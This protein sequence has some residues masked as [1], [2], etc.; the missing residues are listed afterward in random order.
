VIDDNAPCVDVI[1]RDVEEALDLLAVQ[2]HGHDTVGPRRGD[3]V[4]DKLG[5]D[6][7]ARAMLPTVLTRIAE[8]RDHG[9]HS[10][11]R[12]ALDA[13][14]QH[15]ELHQVLVDRRTGRLD[16]EDVLAAEVLHQLDGDLTIREA[17]DL[18]PPRLGAEVSADVRGELRVGIP[19]QDD[20]LLIDV[21][22][23]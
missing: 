7:N 4:R 22:D 12:G 2:V 13:L 10:G 18:R 20:E 6:G 21:V 5:G 17:R 14:D 19:V 11:R 1:D 3:E 8:V 23:H 16:D 15:E 9:R